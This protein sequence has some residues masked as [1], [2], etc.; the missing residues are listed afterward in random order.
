[1]IG[2]RWIKPFFYHSLGVDRLP[3]LKVASPGSPL[4]FDQRFA[5]VHYKGFI[6]LERL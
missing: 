1:M 2:D 6:V 4:P 5:E 3:G